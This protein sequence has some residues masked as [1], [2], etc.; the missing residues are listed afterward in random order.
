MSTENQGKKKPTNAKDGDDLNMTLGETPQNDPPK[1][2]PKVAEELPQTLS[3]IEELK[4]TNAELIQRN[5]NLVIQME[6]IMKMQAQNLSN[7]SSADTAAVTAAVMREV[8]KM[9]TS[10]DTRPTEI[11][12]PDD[13][14]EPG[15]P[16]YYIGSW[17]CF[18]SDRRGNQEVFP[19]M[20]GTD[21]GVIIFRQMES[22][23]SRS[24][25]QEE[26]T[27]IS[28]F[29]STSKKLT[30]WLRNTTFYKNGLIFDSR[31]PKDIHGNVMYAQ[32]MVQIMNGLKSTPMSSLITIARDLGVTMTDDAEQ[33]RASIAVAQIEKEF[34]VTETGAKVLRE[35][36]DN[37]YKR[38][39]EASVL[40]KKVL[41]P[42]QP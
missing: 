8:S 5:E 24:G 2:Q 30:E 33:L 40:N 36:H 12:D 32:R 41:I 39:D 21:N 28:Y 23:R 18:G 15:T 16:F 20:N 25:R 4:K 7:T 42:G 19:P 29:K 6:K 26:I 14:E 10:N 35:W 38:M 22:R 13:V 3:D 27:H 1:P 9:N 31:P 17:F 11:V 34:V 37:N